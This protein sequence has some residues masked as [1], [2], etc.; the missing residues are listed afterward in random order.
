[1][2]LA[3]V[4]GGCFW[5]VE[6]VFQ[7]LE[8]VTKVVSGYAGGQ[9]EN[10]NYKQVCTGLTGHAEVC[11]ITY[12]PSVVSF[13][14]ILEVFWQTHDPTTL[15]R[16]GNDVGPQYRSGIYLHDESQRAVAQSVWDDAQA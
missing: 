2:E 13:D 15:N 9:T 5:C 6:A 14:E 7:R 12:D 11:Q 4:G 8:G 16:Q 3:T 10:P 1:M